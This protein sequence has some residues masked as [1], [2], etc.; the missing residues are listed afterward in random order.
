M[1]QI[2][3]HCLKSVNVPEDAAGKDVTCPECGQTFT[4]PARYDPVVSAP[5]PAAPAP[6][7]APP[8]APVLPAQA[9]QNVDYQMLNN[10]YWHAAQQ[11]A[12]YYA[13]YY[14]GAYGAGQVPSYWYG[15]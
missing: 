8:P 4:P 12:A 7:P 13:N 6:H 3:P 2:C 1:K 11:N 9:I 15:N 14:Q 5:P 10:Y